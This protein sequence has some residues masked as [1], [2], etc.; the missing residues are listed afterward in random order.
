M[1]FGCG[2]KW[3]R[4]PC[5]RSKFSLDVGGHEDLHF[6]PNAENASHHGNNHS[7]HFRF[8][9]RPTSD[10]GFDRSPLLGKIWS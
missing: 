10:L 6:G 8:H 3:T 5:F 9:V 7:D 1:R 2:M 4:D